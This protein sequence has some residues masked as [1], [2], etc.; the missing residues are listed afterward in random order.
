MTKNWLH[1]WAV[2]PGIFWVDTAAQERTPRQL[3]SHLMKLE[4]KTRRASTLS[5]SRAQHTRVIN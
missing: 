1:C 2:C 4:D 5:V 3:F